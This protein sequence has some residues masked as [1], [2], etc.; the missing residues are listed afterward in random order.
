MT[1]IKKLFSHHCT[2]YINIYVCVYI[3]YVIYKIYVVIW[4]RT[5]SWNKNTHTTCDILWYIPFCSISSQKNFGHHPFNWFLEP[6]TS[7]WLFVCKTLAFLI[8]LYWTW[9]GILP[10]FESFSE[11]HRHIF[12]PY[13]I[14]ITSKTTP[15]N[16]SAPSLTTDRGDVE[17]YDQS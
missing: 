1:H 10:C 8:G 3:K 14:Y 7:G 12:Y 13:I 16:C 2:V 17:S 11:S 4:E 15:H 6:P 5:I 9:Q